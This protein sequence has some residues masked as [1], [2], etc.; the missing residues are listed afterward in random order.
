MSLGYTEADWEEELEEELGDDELLGDGDDD[1][2]HS[3]EGRYDVSG[4]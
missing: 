2:I 1:D 4:N 3:D